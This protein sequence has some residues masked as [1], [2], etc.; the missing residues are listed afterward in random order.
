MCGSLNGCG[1]E[2]ASVRAGQSRDWLVEVSREVAGEMTAA[3]SCRVMCTVVYIRLLACSTI[4]AWL[5][6]ASDADQR[7][8][9][10]LSLPSQRAMALDQFTAISSI[11]II[12]M[13]QR[14]DNCTKICQTSFHT[15]S[16]VSRTQRTS[17]STSTST[18]VFSDLA[19]L[20][21]DLSCGPLPIR[22]VA[23][24][25]FW[26]IK[27]FYGGINRG[28]YPPNSH[29]ALP[30]NSHVS[31]PPPFPTPPTFST[32]ADNF[33]SFCTQFCAVLCVFQ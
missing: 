8:F 11:I 1:A 23:R 2:S 33:W 32:P 5:Q 24:N 13:A 7:S 15:G 16:L 18:A 21:Q 10:H 25:L 9:C 30:P 28:V 31:T 14:R 12:Y 22:G 27:C 17:N 19:A 6:R 4:N 3:S 26:G 20:P 29:G